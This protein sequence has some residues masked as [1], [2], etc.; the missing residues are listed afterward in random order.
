MSMADF[1]KL[2]KGEN[3]K[4]KEPKLSLDDGLYL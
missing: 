1:Q 2:I 4:P 3:A